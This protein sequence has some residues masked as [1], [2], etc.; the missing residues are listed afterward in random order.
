MKSNSENHDIEAEVALIL[1]SRRALQLAHKI[2]A[3]TSLGDYRFVPEA[4]QCLRDVYLDTKWH[5]LGDCKMAL[6]IREIN[7]NC[8]LTLKGPSRAIAGASQIERLEIE[9][10]WSKNALDKICKELQ[11]RKIQLK[12]PMQPFDNRMSPID[13]MKSRGLEVFQERETQR[14]IRNMQLQREPSSKIAELAIDRCIYHFGD[15]YIGF[16]EVE[17]ESKEENG[18][19]AL[20][21]LVQE[22]LSMFKPDLKKWGYGKLAMGIAIENLLKDASFTELIDDKGYLKPEAFDAI[23]SYLEKHG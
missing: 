1:Y 15:H 4:A 22:L 21:F 12:E 13:V 2:A 7:G 5:S 10:A 9:Y 14:T 20:N 16:Y 8:L 18:P 19:A 6:R 17:I 3:L 23:E 11:N